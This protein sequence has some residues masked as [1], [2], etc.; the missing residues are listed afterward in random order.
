MSWKSLAFLVM[1]GIP[2]EHA[3][4]LRRISPICPSARTPIKVEL[5]EPSGSSASMSRNASNNWSAD[6]QRLFVDSSLVMTTVVRLP[7]RGTEYVLPSSARRMTSLGFRLSS[8]MS[9]SIFTTTLSY[10][11]RCVL[12][13]GSTQARDG[14]AT[15]WITED[16]AISLT[17]VGEWLTNTC[18]SCWKSSRSTDG[19]SRE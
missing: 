15:L 11:K 4:R 12:V 1:S 9:R 18:C 8:R 7:F 16:A 19:R 10:N 13:A 5:F 14:G 6:T 17:T 3:A 2:S